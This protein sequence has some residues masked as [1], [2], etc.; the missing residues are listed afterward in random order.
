M[1]YIEL[2]LSHGGGGSSTRFRPRCRLAA[3][4][5]AARA[6]R[7]RPDGLRSPSGR[8][9]SRLGRT[10]N[11]RETSPYGLRVTTTSASHRRALLRAVNEQILESARRLQL[12]KIHL[13]FHC[14]CGCASCHEMAALL[15]SEYAQA[16]RPADTILLVP[17]HC[18]RSDSGVIER[19]DQRA[20]SARIVSGDM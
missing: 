11:Y 15:P 14:E 12:S 2:F 6:K 18:A 1:F 10:N 8:H 9:S 16:T 5:A 7:R 19:M 17:D 4:F 20:V 3:A 13:T